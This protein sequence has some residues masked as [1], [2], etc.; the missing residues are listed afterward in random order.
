MP[1]AVAAGVPQSRRRT[2]RDW[3]EPLGTTTGAPAVGPATASS[4]PKRLAGCGAP[5]GERLVP[6]QPLPLIGLLGREGPSPG[7]GGQ[8]PGRGPSPFSPVSAWLLLP[9]YRQVAVRG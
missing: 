1:D 7:S 2:E 8:C 6:P 4:P 3:Q 9:D 5:Q